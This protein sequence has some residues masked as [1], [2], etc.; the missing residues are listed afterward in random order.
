MT[1]RMPKEPV[2]EKVYATRLPR[3]LADWVEEKAQYYASDSAFLSY[4]LEVFAMEN[5][6]KPPEGY[7]KRYAHY[8]PVK[9]R[10]E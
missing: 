10:S 9:G 4:I 8:P 3:S 5:G 7:R 2:S 1:E 6:Y